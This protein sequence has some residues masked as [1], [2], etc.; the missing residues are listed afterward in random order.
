MRTSVCCFSGYRPEKMAHGYQENSRL[1]A[2]LQTDLCQS[3]RRAY[4]QGC[5]HFLSGMSRGF[6][7]WAA[8]A[9]LAVR[10]EGLPID[11]WAAIAFPDMHTRWELLWQARYRHMLTQASQTFHIFP[12]YT[13]ECYI[14][15]DRF[16][17][18][19]SS[20]CIC[21]FDGTAG[22]TAYTVKYA[23]KS[24]LVIDNLAD[25][26]LSLFD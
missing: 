5:L 25:N 4:A 2:E 15:R 21:F 23:Q 26:Q 3:I 8:Q 19:H 10:G 11:L 16:L 18:D 14:V 13:P 24:H 17:V 12:Q 6:D 9:V 1:F 7:L 22:G 20:R